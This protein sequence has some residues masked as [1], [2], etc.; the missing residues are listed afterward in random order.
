[1]PI[2]IPD[3]VWELLQAPSYVHLSTLRADGSPC[4]WVSIRIIR[5]A[6]AVGV[7]PVVFHFHGGGWILG[8]KDTNE[9]LDR[10]L[11]NAA[12]AVVVFVDYT[13]AP[14]AQYPV[15]NEQAYTTL[16]GAIAN[17]AGIGADPARV[18]LAGDGAG[19]NM[20]AA[21]TLMAKERGGPQI[22]AQVLFCPVTD[23]NLGARSLH[24]ARSP[25]AISAH[26]PVATFDRVCRMADPLTLIRSKAVSTTSNL[27][28]DPGYFTRYKNFALGRSASGVLTLRF[29]TDGGPHTFDGTTHHDFPRLLDDIAFDTD[30]RVLGTHSALSTARHVT[31]VGM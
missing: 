4:N 11:A 30:N 7:L 16:Q 23:A 27:T 17:A 10:E 1:M 3:D 13:P 28:Q 18:A 22:A 6:R 19:G 29:H 5:P 2:P 24:R 15:Q 20:T 31:Y 21:L 8:D 26:L 12:Q 14:D 9:R 25:G